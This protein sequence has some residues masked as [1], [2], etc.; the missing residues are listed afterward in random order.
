MKYVDTLVSFSE[1]PDEITLCINISNC[2]NKCEGCHSSWLQGNI[3][4]ELN[5]YELY[6]IINKNS[7]ISCVCFMGGDSNPEEINNLAIKIKSKNLK[8]GWY[9]GNSE[10]SDKINIKNFDY[11]KIGPYLKDKGP[12]SDKNTNQ[13]MYKIIHFTGM[14]SL[15]DITYKF[16]K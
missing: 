1:I 5:N 11:I 8:V 14:N 15:K 6:D 10:I 4:I 9:S 16:W 12:L 3:G 2:P 7:G 13:K